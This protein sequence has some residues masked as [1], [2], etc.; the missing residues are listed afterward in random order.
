MKLY[1]I[2]IPFMAVFLFTGFQWK[3]YHNQINQLDQVAINSLYSS[4]D[5]DKLRNY[6]IE[7]DTEML[8]VN[9]VK[10]LTLETDYLF[11]Y[12]LGINI[13]NQD[14]VVST[15]SLTTILDDIEMQINKSYG[16]DTTQ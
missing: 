4:V 9:V 13:T 7:V 5:I 1:I 2:L 6:N 8:M 14:P 10:F 16:V 3:V 15:I 11:D 12:Q